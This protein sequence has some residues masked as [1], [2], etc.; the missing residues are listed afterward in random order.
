VLNWVTVRFRCFG[1][2]LRRWQCCLG[3]RRARRERKFC[4]KWAAGAAVLD[5][6]IEVLLGDVP[7]SRSDDDEFLRGPPNVLAGRVDEAT[8]LRDGWGKK[9]RRPTDGTGRSAPLPACTRRRECKER[10]LR[11]RLQ[12]GTAEV[13]LILAVV[14]GGTEGLKEVFLRRGWAERRTL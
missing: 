9:R 2:A 12:Y 1:R 7:S 10:G 5:F 13:G 6:V 3:P 8:P 11:W 4:S 14:A